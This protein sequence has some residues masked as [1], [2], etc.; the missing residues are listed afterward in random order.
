MEGS[1]NDKM[2]GG[3][4]CDD[5]ATLNDRVTFY[6]VKYMHRHQ[7]GALIFLSIL[8]NISSDA[9]NIDNERVCEFVGVEG[10]EGITVFLH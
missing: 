2:S 10:L 3:S 7:E 4:F 6:I 9:K 1:E 8:I 5:K